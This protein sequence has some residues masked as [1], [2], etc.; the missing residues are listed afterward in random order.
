M[1]DNE[2]VSKIQEYSKED[3][4]VLMLWNSCSFYNFSNR[5]YEGKYMYQVPPIL[6]DDKILNE[7]LE[8]LENNKPDLIVFPYEYERFQKMIY[9]YDDYITKIKETNPEFLEDKT[10]FD[11][12]NKRI[13]DY[14]AE[15]KNIRIM[16]NKIEEMT[17]EGLYTKT[18]YDNYTI[19]KLN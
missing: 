19:W 16:F 4:N 13:E 6:S 2:I 10:T 17:K 3:D 18:I 1:A 15:I 8:E 5:K 7:I 12:I 14:F 9:T 11:Y